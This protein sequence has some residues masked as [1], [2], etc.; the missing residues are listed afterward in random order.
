MLGAGYSGKGMKGYVIWGVQNLFLTP[1]YDWMHNC[2]RDWTRK[3]DPAL[4]TSTV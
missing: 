1:A 3:W 2:I 4:M